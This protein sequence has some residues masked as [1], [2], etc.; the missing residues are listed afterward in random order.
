MLVCLTRRQWSENRSLGHDR[1]Q[2]PS[3]VPQLRFRKRS[4]YG[5]CNCRPLSQMPLVQIEVGHED[6]ERE[7]QRRAR[8]SITK[9]HEIQMQ[10]QETDA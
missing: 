10:R 1:N 8:A 9:V 6:P 7:I 3:F 2:A 4:P 5:S